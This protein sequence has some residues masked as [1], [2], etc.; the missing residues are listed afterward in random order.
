[1]L[2]VYLDS[3]VIVKRYVSETDS[4]VVDYVFDKGWA[5]EL[6]MATSIWNFG[7]VLGVLDERRRRKWLSEEEFT[8]VLENFTSEIIR[9]LHLKILEVF[10]VLNTML[11]ETWPLILK[12]HIY[13][14]DALQIQTCVYSGS[15]VLLSSDKN[16]VSAAQKTGLKAV[17]IKDENRVRELISRK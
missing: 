12:E 1:M 7:E 4:L 14:A 13:E 8:K 16:L 11:V 6:S 5:G 15:D 17:N 2:K 3:S 10:P 9:L